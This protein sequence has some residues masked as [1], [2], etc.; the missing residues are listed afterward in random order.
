VDSAV[1]DGLPRGGAAPELS[2]ASSAAGAISGAGGVPGLAGVWASGVF[3][4]EPAPHLVSKPLALLQGHSA[5][6][7]RLACDQ[8][9]WL[10]VSA[11][12]DKEMRVWDLRSLRPLHTLRDSY[13]D[14][15]EDRLAALA[16]DP[17]H[18]RL[19]VGTSVIRLWG[20]RAVLATGAPA[21]SSGR[22]CPL[23]GAVWAPQFG[24]FI[25][26][27]EDGNVAVWDGGSG[28][29]ISAFSRTHGSA[30]LCC[31]ALDAAGRRLLTGGSDG[32]VRLWNYSNGACVRQLHNP[33]PE[34]DQAVAAHSSTAAAS[35]LGGGD[36][37]CGGGGAGAAGAS[38]CSQAGQSRYASA[39]V[40]ATSATVAATP[41]SAA[42][43]RPSAA[44]RKAAAVAAVAAAAGDSLTP[45]TDSVT[46]RDAALAAVA[47]GGPGTAAHGANVCALIYSFEPGRGVR[48][49]LAAGW[50][51]KVRF[52]AEGLFAG[53][54]GRVEGGV[55]DG[56]ARVLGE[57]GPFGLAVEKTLLGWLCAR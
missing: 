39:G 10:L 23:V 33:Q 2:R 47:R 9:R 21:R 48:R 32:R 30:R 19:L 53:E 25:T 26:A 8:A 28:G 31:V 56:S 22:V 7:V 5:P 55:W 50:N 20:V 34:P 1:G 29:Y 35:A 17:A 37:I 24:Q 38:G 45:R 49:I 12:A 11:A 44:S 42:R 54:R 14:R 46:P 13:A 43:G 4:P 52:L 41:P 6:V 15:P 57:R 3:Q 36:E 18:S 51:R 40:G 27:D 16:W